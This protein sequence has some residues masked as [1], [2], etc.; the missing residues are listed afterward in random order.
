MTSLKIKRGER[1]FEIPEITTAQ[2][3]YLMDLGTAVGTSDLHCFYLATKY[4]KGFLDE[5]VGYRRL[6]LTKEER[7]EGMTVRIT[8]YGQADPREWS[9]R[10]KRKS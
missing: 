9:P 2:A 10:S 6:P 3:E 4:H 7:A 8:F 1:V 5:V